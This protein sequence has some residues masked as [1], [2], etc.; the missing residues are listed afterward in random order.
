MTRKQKLRPMLFAAIAVPVLCTLVFLLFERLFGFNA[1]LNDAW[2]DYFGVFGAVGSLVTIIALAIGV[3]AL[4]VSI[5][6]MR[7]TEETARNATTAANAAANAA[8]EAIDEIRKKYD[9]HLAARASS[10]LNSAHQFMGDDSKLGLS[11]LRLGDLA[12][13]LQQIADGDQE[14]AALSARV[15]SME[16]YVEGLIQ[17]QRPMPAS[18]FKKWQVLRIEINDKIV[19]KTS[20]FATVSE[21][22]T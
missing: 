22:H 21:E 2:R 18:Q 14:W 12:E 4:W 20:P 16:T 13:H 5:A 19:G 11:V 10:L 1:W 6:Q 7:Q 8:A 17:K 15:R 3:Y 9:S